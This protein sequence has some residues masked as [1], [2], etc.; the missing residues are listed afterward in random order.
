MK[1]TG[2]IRRIDELGRVVIPKELRRV[3]KLKEGELLEIFTNTEGELILKKYNEVAQDPKQIQALCKVLYKTTGKQTFIC[4]TDN[5]IAHF[6]GEKKLVGEGI[7]HEL[8]ELLDNRKS[9]HLTKTI[10][11]FDS[12][13]IVLDMPE[14]YVVPVISSGDL[15]GGIILSADKILGQDFA[16]CDAMA[17]YISHNISQ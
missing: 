14:K 15:Y 6:G 3:L 11:M 8:Y 17:E 12:D 4:D 9:I 13:D 16:L 2:M 5:I 7:S 10:N 1:E